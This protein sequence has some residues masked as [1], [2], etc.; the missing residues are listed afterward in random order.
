MATRTAS[1]GQTKT[2]RGL[3]FGLPLL[4]L[5]W[6]TQIGQIAVAVGVSAGAGFLLSKVMPRGPANSVQTL[7]VMAACLAVGL[8]A[9]TAHPSRWVI[10]LAPLA[11]I[12]AFELGRIGAVGP[13]VDL[14]HLDTT[15]GILAFVLGRGFHA[16]VGLLPLAYG[17][18]L[19]V[20][21][22]RHFLSTCCP[23]GTIP[24]HY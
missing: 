19:G 9:G 2:S 22:G 4:Q 5:V 16:V 6:S 20:R 18:S 21:I 11:H 1:M 8:M 7:I 17:A 10:L 12:A 23:N 13:T 14:P 15:Y 3:V 24:E